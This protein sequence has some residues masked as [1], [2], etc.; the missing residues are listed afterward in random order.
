MIDYKSGSTVF[1]KKD[2]EEGRALQSALYSLA[3]EALLPDVSCVAESYYLHIPTR[4]V[5]GRIDSPDGATSCEAVNQAVRCAAS[6][7][8]AVCNGR[9]PSAPGKPGQGRRACNNTCDF[10]SLCRMTRQSTAKAR[11]IPAARAVAEEE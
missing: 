7:V 3:V 10:A 4:E 1:G 5:S 2:I 11:L 8:D 9:F 6:A